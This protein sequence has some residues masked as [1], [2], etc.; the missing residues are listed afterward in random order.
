MVDI[1]L[2][3]LTFMTCSIVFTKIFFKVFCCYFSF[4]GSHINLWFQPSFF[5]E[6][7]G[8]KLIHD[9]VLDFKFLCVQHILFHYASCL[10]VFKT[11]QFLI[12]Q[13]KMVSHCEAYVIFQNFEHWLQKNFLNHYLDYNCLSN[14]H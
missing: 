2:I 4:L 12:F 5:I 1:S 11:F 13:L 9:L 6:F 10:Q 3:C 14:L 7:N 8:S